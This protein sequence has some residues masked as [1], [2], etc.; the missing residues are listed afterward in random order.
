MQ[1]ALQAA[2]QAA[3]RV[4]QQAAVHAAEQATQQLPQLSHLNLPPIL[5]PVAES[6]QLTVETSSTETELLQELLTEVM[7]L[8]QEERV[9]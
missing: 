7:R 2:Q 8:A 5:Q 6:K 1:A 4:A 9:N 3:V